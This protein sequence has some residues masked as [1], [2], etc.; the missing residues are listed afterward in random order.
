MNW[1]GVLFGAAAAWQPAPISDDGFIASYG[2]A[3]HNDPTGK[4]DDAQRE[5]MAANM[6]LKN[7]GLEDAEDRLYWA[8][9]FSPAGEAIAAK[10]RPV[11]SE[12]R[13]HAE[14]AITL[15][16]QARA[17]AAAD[18]RELTNPEAL[19]ALELGA[20]RIDAVGLKFQAADDCVSLYARAQSL[21][22]DK[23]NW[24]EVEAL[25]ETIGS[26]NGRLADIRDGYTLIGTLYRQAWLR[27]N[28]PY[29]LPNNMVQF[30]RAAQLWMGRSDR[31][32]QLIDRWWSTH[33]L[34]PAAE[35]G[36]PQP[37]APVALAQ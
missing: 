2:Q 5:L 22:G 35:A 31:W 13:L 10:I 24:N 21:A 18:H 33:T 20:R 32:D 6:T 4:I 37:P 34:P 9:P 25:L 11:L 23:K 17:A 3:F 30:D 27:D 12:L 36:L 19:D 1:F 26:N 29:W 28:R 14:R 16:G 8:D 15:V 7:A